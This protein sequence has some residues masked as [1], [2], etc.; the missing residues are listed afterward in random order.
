MGAMQLLKQCS[1]F[2]LAGGMGRWDGNIRLKS[3]GAAAEGVCRVDDIFPR[4]TRTAR[5]RLIVGVVRD[6]V[7]V[8]SVDDHAP[9]YNLSGIERRSALACWKSGG[10]GCEHYERPCS[11][12]CRGL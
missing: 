2:V 12:A 1:A 10:V 9:G 4:C 8:A 11:A 5:S 7:H 6:C 3:A